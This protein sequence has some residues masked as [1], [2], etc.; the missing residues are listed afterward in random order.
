MIQN[1]GRLWD[2][3]TDQAASAPDSGET[4]NLKYWSASRNQMIENSQTNSTE[5]DQH[6]S[7]VSCHH[8][9]LGIVNTMSAV[10]GLE[11]SSK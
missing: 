1:D 4:G 5:R 2:M 10:A 6:E 7:I 11:V 9:R 3:T 8:R